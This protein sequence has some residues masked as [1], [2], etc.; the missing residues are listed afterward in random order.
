[1]KRPFEDVVFT[2]ARVWG[3]IS[4]LAILVLPTDCIAAAK[5]TAIVGASIIDATGRAPIERGVLEIEGDRIVRVGTV[6]TRLP[7]NARVIRADG[8]YIIPG[9]MDANVHLV[10]GFSTEYLLRFQDRFADIIREGAQVALKSGVT[11]VFDTWGPLQPLQQVRQEITEGRIPGSRIFLGGNIVGLGGPFSPDF[12]ASTDGISPETVTRIDAQYEEGVGS[13]LAYMSPEGVRAAIQQYLTHGVDFLKFA[14]SG[15]GNRN[16]APVFSPRVTQVIVG[17]VRA[18]GL[19][20]V[21]HTTTVESLQMAVD[22]R[23]DVM[24]HCNLTGPTPIPE[25]LLERIVQLKIACP[26][27]IYPLRYLEHTLGPGYGRPPDQISDPQQ[28]DL[29]VPLFNQQKLIE[30]GAVILMMTDG[31]VPYAH[32]SLLQQVFLSHRY[33]GVEEDIVGFFGPG[34][35][36]WLRAAQEHGMKPMQI[37]QAATRNVAAA[38]GKLKDLGTL[39]PGKFADFVVLNDN[40]LKDAS[41]YSSIASVWKAGQQVDR[42]RLPL[43]PVVSP[44]S[45]DGLQRKSGRGTSGRYS[46]AFKLTC[47]GV[48]DRSRCQ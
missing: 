16:A 17:E 14:I 21:T 4:L 41:H 26:M 22:N 13:E 23:V 15:H 7:R 19:P 47:G 9:L 11:T 28:H 43:H 36:A 12:Y 8:K 37:L 44:V 2:W 33:P 25:E 24:Q 35:A 1:M 40:P 42:A 48:S 46:Y 27:Q 6:D 32:D 45:L 18:R 39:E 30:R 29:A 3:T 20:V 38:Y 5:L 10:Y 31:G 34:H